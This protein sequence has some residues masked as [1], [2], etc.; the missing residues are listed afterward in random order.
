MESLIPVTDK[1]TR[2]LELQDDVSTKILEKKKEINNF[3]DKFISFPKSDHRRVYDKLIGPIERLVTESNNL[4]NKIDEFMIRVNEKAQTQK[5]ELN[6][7]LEILH[8]FSVKLNESKIDTLE[9]LARES[10]A[11]ARINPDE[12]PQRY[13]SVL[14]KQ[15]SGG[16]RRGRGRRTRR[17]RMP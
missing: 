7:I 15:Y 6:E 17:A 13:R 14:K 11:A 9:E 16:R 2:I 12:L 8:N 1:Y 3:F 10:A 5:N 4:T